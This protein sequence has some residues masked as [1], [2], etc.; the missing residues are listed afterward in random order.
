MTPMQTLVRLAELTREIDALQLAMPLDTDRLRAL[1]TER[2]RI[3]AAV[4]SV[5][6]ELEGCN[7]AS[8]WAH[9]LEMRYP[10]AA[11]P[12]ILDVWFAAAL[13]GGRMDGIKEGATLGREQQSDAQ[14]VAVKT[15]ELIAGLLQDHKLMDL[16]LRGGAPGSE[17]KLSAVVAEALGA[18]L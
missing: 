7:D 17:R 6:R 16:R 2:D 3:V 8:L 14:G 13:A 15:L 9:M 11:P 10:C 18:P 1:R 5:P 4:P 12:G